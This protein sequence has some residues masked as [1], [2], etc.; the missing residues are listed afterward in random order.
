MAQEGPEQGDQRIIDK[1]AHRSVLARIV[2]TQLLPPERFKGEKGGKVVEIKKIR[3]TVGVLS[4]FED[5]FEVSFYDGKGT[6]SKTNLD[7][8]SKGVA[9]NSTS[10]YVQIK[11]DPT[12]ATIQPVEGVFRLMGYS[13]EISLKLKSKWLQAI[14]KSGEI[15]SVTNN[16]SKSE[17]K[18][19]EPFFVQLGQWSLSVGKGG[20]GKER[21]IATVGDASFDF[22]VSPN[23]KNSIKQ[24]SNTELKSLSDPETSLSGNLHLRKEGMMFSITDESGKVLANY[25]GTEPKVDPIDPDSLY[26]INTGKIYRLDLKGVPTRSSTPIVESRFKVDDPQ[27]LDF[28]PN[29]NLLIVRQKEDKL[30]V[31]EKETG[32]EIRSFPGVSG[33][34]MVDDQGDIIYAEAGGKI[35]EIQ[36]NFQAIPAGGTEAARQKREDELQ[37]MQER[38]ADLKIEEVQGTKSEGISE[39]KVAATLRKTLSGQVTGV[40]TAATEPE[41][42]EAVLDKLQVLKSDPAY[43]EYGLVV[44]EFVSQA[45]EKLSSIQTVTLRGGLNNFLQQLDSVESVGDT[46]GLDEQFARLLQLRQRVEILDVNTRREIEKMIE[47]I[48]TK[49]ES[50]IKQYQTEL[51]TTVEQALPNIDTLIR[52]SGSLQELG[53][54]GTTSAAQQF[55]RML[56]NI[57]DPQARREWR[58]RLSQIKETQRTALEAR[59][60]ELEEQQRLRW[61]QVVEEA[62]GDLEEI[63]NQ[64]GAIDDLKE[65]GRFARNPLVTA[66]RARLYSL[67]PELR[68]IEER[69]LE[70]LLSSRKQDLEHRKDLGAIGE[71]GELRFGK[72]TFSIYKEP[73]RIWQPKLVPLGKGSFSEWAQL[74]FE[75]TQGRV[76]KPDSEH[77]TLVANDMGNERTIKLIGEF[78]RRAEEYFKSIK[79][80]VPE[81]DE[82]WRITEYHMQRLEEIVEA[83]NL[84]SAHHRGILI[85]QG[86]AGTGKNVLVDMLANLSNREV[87]PILCNEN[88]SKEDLTYEFYYDPEKGTYKLPSKLVEALQTPGAIIL[89]DEINALKPGIAK[90]LNSL[91][92]YRRRI[93]LAEGGKEREIIVDPTVLFVGTMNPQNYAGVNRLSPE[94]KSRAR[95]VDLDYPPF[96]E[97]KSGR[98]VWNSYEAEMLAANMDSLRELKQQE[99]KLCWDYV[100]NHDATNGAEII[101]QGD[102][103]KEEDIRRIHDVLRVANKLREMYQ[104]YQVG[105]A[106]EP[107]DF[108]VSLREVI[109]IVLEMNHR[110]GVKEIIKRVIIPKIDDRR[111]KRL[112]GE[113]IEA[114]LP[115]P[116][117]GGVLI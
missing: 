54:F 86:E 85:L 105:D 37:K 47:G 62:K 110:K 66:W 117:P 97:I 98:T 93:Y 11:D 102:P 10:E 70:V 14:Q 109:D 20:D 31:L 39:E 81:F 25:S 69:R 115:E 8:S 33:P 38:F 64:I 4:Q 73:P 40:I 111:Q 74:V 72:A 107:M 34:V 77:E 5:H 21:F 7:P 15:R 19:K 55:E 99:F 23:G 94:V 104:A 57:R 108:P 75:D 36:T 22:M 50:L 90:L 43:R 9:E 56:A 67:P 53:A 45:K 27:E 80:K 95:V 79:R 60:R 113:T 87:I 101:L 13:E 41:A 28:D 46:I 68:E 91:F 96:E 88:S 112:V 106:N 76:W 32:D 29:G 116:P 83:L 114:V 65:V 48:Q 42:L 82:H 51:L 1:G 52:E 16:F 35:R 49:K 61:A 58:D 59:G 6:E 17:L 89:F 12:G 100:V 30:V 18:K 71:A 92:D 3:D 24:I 63:R 2:E 26:F 103:S 78:R 44:D 84:Q